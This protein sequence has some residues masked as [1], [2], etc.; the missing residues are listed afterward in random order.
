MMSPSAERAAYGGLFTAAALIFSYAE[1]FIPLNAFIPI[2]GFKLGLSNICVMLAFYYLGTGT[3]FFITLAKS[4]LTALLFGTPISFLFSLCGGLFAF[5]FL[6]AAKYLIKEKISFI[7]ISVAC[8]ALH[9]VG[10]VC[11]A[12]L[13]FLDS[14]VFLYLEWL[15]P[16]SIV[17][18][19]VTGAIA[20]GFSAVA[21]KR[22][23]RKA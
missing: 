19:I 22:K 23:E 1:T 15:L 10:Q 6:L 5:C 16:V 20:M 14:A 7:G 8:A 11:M 2:P 12:S 21:D 13:L 3:A 18:G 17:T 4:G 9:N